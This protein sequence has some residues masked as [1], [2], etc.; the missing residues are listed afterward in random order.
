MESVYLNDNNA[1]ESIIFK[2]IPIKKRRMEPNEITSP[3]DIDGL[4]W[5]CSFHQTSDS[6]NCVFI[7]QKSTLIHKTQIHI[8]NFVVDDSYTCKD[9]CVY[10][11]LSNYIYDNIRNF[12]I[13]LPEEM[14][15]AAYRLLMDLQNVSYRPGKSLA[16]LVSCLFVNAD[17][18][19]VLLSHFRY[20]KAGK[21]NLKITHIKL[22]KELLS[23]GSSLLKTACASCKLLKYKN[24]PL[25]A[26][27]YC[28]QCL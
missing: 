1:E 2:D 18:E 3:I 17:D 4:I 22:L 26:H 27:N 24:V 28:K 11:T 9:N 14:F 20:L 21:T 5:S 8:S 13:N 15:L 23:L 12:N 16:D 10:E 25:W 6:F 19:V 7:K